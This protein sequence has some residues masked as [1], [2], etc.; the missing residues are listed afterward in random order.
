MRCQFVYDS[1]NFTLQGVSAPVLINRLRFR[2]ATTTTSWAG[3]SW[4]NVRI[5]M[6]TCPLDY[7]AVSAT[8]ASNLGPDLTTVYQGQV[9][10]QAGTGSGPTNWHIDIQL[11]TPFPYDPGSGDLTMDVQLD[12]TGW[13]GTATQADHVSGATAL[14]SRIFNTT[15]ATAASGT[16]G[17]SYVAVCEFGYA[18]GG[19]GPIATNTSL[20]LGCV[21]QFASFY[22]LFATPAAFDLAN[23]AITMIPT[24]TGYVVT[25]GGAFLPVGSVQAVPTALALGDDTA[26]TQPFTVGTFFDSSGPWTGVNVISNGCVA[27]AAGNT[28][29][30]APS[31]GTMLADPQTGFYTQADYDP[32]GGAGAGTIWFEES[33]SVI[34]VTWDHV[35]SWNNPGSQNTFQ[36][37]LYPSGVV[38]IAWVAMAAVGSNGGV[39]VGYSPGGASADPGST[40]LSTLPVIILSSP[41]V[42][43]LALAGASRPV[44]GTNWNLNVTNVPA[45][46]A[47]GVDIFG[48]SDPGIN[49][50]GFIGMPTCGLRASLDV[51]N[52]WIVAGA[53]HAYGVPV[54]NNPALI[55][56]HV[57]TTSAVFQVPPVNAFGAITSNGIDGKI[58]SQ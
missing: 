10:V 24:G 34:T 32:I 16:V 26:V 3:G 49:D 44:T 29:V 51:L 37:Q 18:P 20:G 40:D 41:D 28:T 30:A 33:S 6:A 5:D 39:L 2:P 14:G 48:L 27:K 1:T 50:L 42:L 25:P 13:T 17:T 52:A 58:G 43:P 4:P 55:N 7:S 57:F 38:T 31:P 22:E 8:Y 45:T 19:S 11:T 12:G 23:S 15:S 36:M 53:S 35:A 21:R 9:V 56:Q 47:I 46:G 54:P